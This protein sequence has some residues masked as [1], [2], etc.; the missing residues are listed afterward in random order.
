M[1]ALDAEGRFVLA[2]S[3]LC[4]FLGLP[5]PSFVGLRLGELPPGREFEQ[6][7]ALGQ[8]LATRLC[9]EG[10]DLRLC[11]AQGRL[12]E[13]ILSLADYADAG[14]RLGVVAALTDITARKAAESALLES[15]EKYRA[16]REPARTSWP[17]PIRRAASWRSTRPSRTCTAWRLPAQSGSARFPDRRCIAAGRGHRAARL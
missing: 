3:A 2:N 6:L 4:Q 15:R 8:A 14:G 17:S 9:D 11:D 16:V 12:H 7:S 10:G 5:G 13:F 1:A